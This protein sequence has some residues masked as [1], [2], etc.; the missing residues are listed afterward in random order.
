MTGG[1]AQ[2]FN[3][4]DYI[5]ITDVAEKKRE[6]CDCH[7]SQGMD[8]IYNNWHDIMERFR[9]NEHHCKRAEAFIHLRRTGNDI[10]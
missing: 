8:G 10:L 7:V 5:D 1:Q 2:L 6:A 9:G 3:P 4:T